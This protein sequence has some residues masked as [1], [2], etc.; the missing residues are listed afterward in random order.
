MVQAV[1]V[2]SQYMSMLPK[3]SA[4]RVVW[5]PCSPHFSRTDAPADRRAR[6]VMWQRMSCS[7]NS[8][9]PT[10]NVAPCSE[11]LCARLPGGTLAFELMHPAVTVV[12]VTVRA[13]RTIRSG[14]RAGGGRTTGSPR[15]G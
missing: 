5:L 1:P 3:V 9:D 12:R 10:V 15:S 7:V 6:L 14:R 11:A 13:V 4:A 8:L 2:Y